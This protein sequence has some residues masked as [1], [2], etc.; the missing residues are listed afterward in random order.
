MVICTV[1]ISH[2]VVVAPS[3]GCNSEVVEVRLEEETD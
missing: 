2:L 3:A 1:R